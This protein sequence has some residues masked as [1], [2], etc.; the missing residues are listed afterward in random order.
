MLVL[1]VRSGGNVV[2]VL[3]FTYS[4]EY[5]L[6]FE[7]PQRA[8]RDMHSPADVVLPISLNE[9]LACLLVLKLVSMECD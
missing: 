3:Y 7:E 4:D 6:L 8:L 5:L 2:Y 1:K 9:V